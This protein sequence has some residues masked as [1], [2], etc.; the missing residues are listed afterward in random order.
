MRRDKR[1][2][3]ENYK[4]Q[5]MNKW[6]EI[7]LAFIANKLSLIQSKYTVSE[8]LIYSSIRCL[9]Y[10]TSV[11]KTPSVNYV[12][13]LIALMWEYVDHEKYDL[14]RVI[15]KFLSRIGY[16]TSAIVV[17]HNFDRSKC[18][19]SSLESPID[20]ILTTLNQVNNSVSVNNNTFLITDFQ[21][22]IWDSMD[23]ERLIGISA[24]TSA[25]K[26]FVILLKILKKLCSKK[27][28]VVYIV[29]TLSLLNQVSEDF[30]KTIQQLN[31]SD[32]IV[33]NAYVENSTS[34]VN[35]IFVLTQEKAIS[36]FSDE[37]N[38][39][40]KDI[41]LVA[42]EIQN[43]ERIKEDNDE[44]AKILYD[45]LNE[46]RYKDN[47]KQII[48][49]GPRI[50][51]IETTGTD[52]FGIKAKDITSHDSPVLNLTYSVC[53][54]K[55]RYYLKQYC[56]LT[57]YP[58]KKRI[59][60]TKI[61][62]GY[63]KKMYDFEF[64]SYLDCIVNSLEH[65]QN[66][67]FSP[68]SSTARKIACSI[69]GDTNINQKLIEL[70]TYYQSSIH[71]KY[72]MCDTLA[73]GIAY[74]HGKLPHHV[75]RTIEIAIR[76]KWV[77]NIVCT[78]TLL[79]GVNLPTQNIIIRN[80][81]LY[82]KKRANSAELSNYEMA[83]LRGRAGR[84][85]KDFIGRT[86]VLDESAFANSEE[87]DQLSLFDDATKELPTGYKER[88]NKY[89]DNIERV[90]S[91]DKP[92]D[93]SMIKYGD[94]VSYIR[95]SVLRYGENS[96]QK[97]KNVGI[98]LTKEQ[99]AAI[100]LKLKE[101]SVPQNIC[102]KNRY[103]DPF[104][105]D[106]IFKNYKEKVPKHP[107]EHGAKAKLD[108]MLKFLRDTPE[109]T[110]M[111]EKYIPAKLQKGNGRRLL[112]SL[113]MQWA[114]ENSLKEILEKVNCSDDEVA[115]EI[116]N[117]IEILQNTVS[118]KVPLL[119]KPIFDIQDPD[120]PF[121]SC[122]Q[123]GAYNPISRVMIEIGVPRECALTLKEMLFQKY[124]CNKK[125]DEEI[126]SDIRTV[127]KRNKDSLPYWIGVQLNFLG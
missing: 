122:M 125:S 78:T 40:T 96:K 110:H 46:F 120:A 113:C 14:R 95:Q 22:K 26:S 57:G 68:T 111:Y 98:N 34:S 67:I 112:C 100:I 115:D 17:D 79:Q 114:K 74:H 13:T 60:N 77:S 43:I 42:D 70:I 1:L 72:S 99:I 64:L 118:Y 31:V 102:T 48:I 51:D 107:Y 105:L 15:V 94:L 106:V 25:G 38:K 83:N 108:R 71:P 109:T 62:Q 7:D 32:C 20:H 10:E 103:W 30:N 47:V 8:E 101:L 86:F 58:I 41:I 87:Y 75:R 29:P 4:N 18:T 56:A 2:Q 39:F 81:Y 76:N 104:V 89:Y 21:K 3:M 69:N 82:V 49:S 91:S 117:R 127:L 63:G 66:I 124:D 52:I 119:L 116:E 90:I 5:V 37:R 50:E 92:V 73:K 12:I 65:Q 53:K 9:D 19:F 123:A 16:P 88:F 28:D 84:L 33:S 80:P 54:E 97:M 121:L 93:V 61:I 35:T 44:R 24:P 6:L 126:E 36:A 27:F 59:T 11:S 23:S 85:L 55:S 45:A